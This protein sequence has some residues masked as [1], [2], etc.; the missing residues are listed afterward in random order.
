M[1]ARPLLFIPVLVAGINPRLGQTVSAAPNFAAGTTTAWQN[2]SFSIDTPNVV[3]RSD[4]VL[5]KANTDPTTFMPLGNGTLGAA[6]W[7]AN[8]FTAQLNRSDTFPD[9]KSPGQVVIPGLS[10]LTT[11]SNFTGFLDRTTGCCTSPAAA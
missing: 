3:R 10:A 8:G 2:G 4:I 1:S 5:G 11:A 7:A 9:R 6:V